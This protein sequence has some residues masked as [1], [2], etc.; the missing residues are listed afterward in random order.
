MN[1]RILLSGVTIVSVVGLVAGVGTY[2]ELLDVDDNR[3]NQ[4]Q[5]GTT[6][7]QADTQSELGGVT[8]GVANQCDD[9]QEDD[10]TAAYQ[11]PPFNNFRPDTATQSD[12]GVRS[13][14]GSF[15]SAYKSIC[16][17]NAGS[18]DGDL[19]VA[20]PA[21]VDVPGAGVRNYENVLHDPEQ[22]AGDTAG[23]RGEFGQQVYLSYIRYA[24]NTDGT[25]NFAEAPRDSTTVTQSINALAGDPAFDLGALDAGETS[26]VA[27]KFRWYSQSTHGQNVNL[28]QDDTTEFDLKWALEQS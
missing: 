16:V 5:A 8:D 19:S 10:Y 28:A 24:A 20:I 17:R 4:L 13:S 14:D 18:V 3:N 23:P 22:E 6:I 11:A 1:K 9:W 15:Q 7:L 12:G 21:G 2:A 25:C 26:C 27:M